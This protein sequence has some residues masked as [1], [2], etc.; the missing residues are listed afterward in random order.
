MKYYFPAKSSSSKQSMWQILKKKQDNSPQIYH[1]S[2]ASEPTD[3][4]CPLL[5]KLLDV[6]LLDNI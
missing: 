3:N 5:P 4:S 6:K 2:L 1:P